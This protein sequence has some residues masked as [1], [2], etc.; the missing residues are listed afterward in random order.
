MSEESE[1]SEDIL[2]EN[3]RNVRDNRDS[4]E[5]GVVRCLPEVRPKTI[6][7]FLGVQ[8]RVYVIT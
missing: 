1:I 3:M 7:L 6:F 2:R 5:N 4:F 8:V